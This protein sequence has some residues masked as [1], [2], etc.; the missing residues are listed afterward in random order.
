MSDFGYSR[1]DGSGVR[2]GPPP[3]SVSGQCDVSAG[4]PGAAERELWTPPHVAPGR[5]GDPE[6]RLEVEVEGGPLGTAGMGKEAKKSDES[7]L[8]LLDPPPLCF[9]FLSDFF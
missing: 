8:F 6:D 3:S 7:H 2:T 5:L 1:G 9:G 4:R